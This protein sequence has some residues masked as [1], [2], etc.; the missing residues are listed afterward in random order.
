MQNASGTHIGGKI[1]VDDFALL[2]GIT[3]ANLARGDE[4]AVR[5]PPQQEEKLL[6]ALDEADREPGISADELFE[7]LRRYG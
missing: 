2:E 1:V 6:D 4:T 3:N 7:R 5:L